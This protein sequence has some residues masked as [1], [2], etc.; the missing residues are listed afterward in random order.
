MLIENQAL[1]QT[2]IYNDLEW[3]WGSFWWPIFY[4]W[5]S[6]NIFGTDIRR[7]FLEFC[8]QIVFGKC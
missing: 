7:L 2:V 8:T 3:S 6:F 1:Y 5:L 4:F